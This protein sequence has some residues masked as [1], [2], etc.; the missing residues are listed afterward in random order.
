MYLKAPYLTIIYDKRQMKT[1]IGL[2]QLLSKNCISYYDINELKQSDY[3][4]FFSMANI[5]WK[6]CPIIPISLYFGNFKKYNYCKHYIYTNDYQIIG[7]FSGVN[8]KTLSEK[9][10]KR[11]ILIIGNDSN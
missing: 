10:I 9:R 8:L 11:K 1:V 2:V 7:G 4:N 5:W 3:L 6:T